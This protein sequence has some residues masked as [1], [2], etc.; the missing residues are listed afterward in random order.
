[1]NKVIAIDFDGTLFENRFP[2][3]GEP[4][5]RVIKKALEEQLHGA[6]LVLW[7]CREGKLLDDALAACAEYGLYFSAVNDSTDEWKKEFDNSPRKIGASEYWDDKSVNPDSIDYILKDQI[8]SLGI[9]RV[10]EVIS[11]AER[12]GRYIT[13]GE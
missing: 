5:M 3:I 1:M 9:S 4:R 13:Y 6:D 10:I 12:E 7:T 11:E 2:A 8:E